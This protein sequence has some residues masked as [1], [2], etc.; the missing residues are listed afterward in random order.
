MIRS[1]VKRPNGGGGLVQTRSW[2]TIKLLGA[3]RAI[4]VTVSSLV[5]LASCASSPRSEAGA[6]LSTGNLPS[7]IGVASIDQVRALAEEIV[8]K[9]PPS[10]RLTV[11]RVSAASPEYADAPGTGAWVSF[12]SDATGDVSRFETRWEAQVALAAVWRQAGE[13]NAAVSGGEL[14]FAGDEPVMNSA[15]FRYSFAQNAF[16]YLFTDRDDKP[17]PMA[18]PVNEIRADVDQAAAELHYSV[19][20]VSTFNVLGTDV[21]ITA[22]TEDPEQLKLSGSPFGFDQGTLE[23]ACFVLLGPD[24]ELLASSSYS[25]GLQSGNGGGGGSALSAG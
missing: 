9:L 14:I 1:A 18:M 19:N 25:T 10:G 2:Q 13:S 8:A 17:S 11:S 12:T 23:G 22:T 24:G 16:N 20:D 21:V 6:E 4:A 15:G 3:T 7:L 5:L